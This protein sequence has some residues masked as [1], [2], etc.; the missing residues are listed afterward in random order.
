MN[1]WL[2]LIPAV[3]LPVLLLAVAHWFPWVRTL[4]R[5]WAYRIGTACLWSGFALWRFLVGDWKTPLGLAV[6]CLVG[7]SAVAFYWWI[8]EQIDAVSTAMNKADKGD[9]MIERMLDDDRAS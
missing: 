7:G 2:Y 8:D 6:I 9:R 4:P 3:T 1:E 5:L